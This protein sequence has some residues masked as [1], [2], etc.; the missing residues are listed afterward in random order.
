MNLKKMVVLFGLAMAMLASGRIVFAEETVVAMTDQEAAVSSQQVALEKESDLQWAWGE[1]TNLDNQAG[2]V[3]LKYL[4]YETDQEKELVL[5]VDEKT[6]FENINDFSQLKL[7]DA[8]SIDYIAG[9]DNKNIAKNIS[10]EKADIS[11]VV[12]V[13]ENS[14][15][16]SPASIAEQP[17]ADVSQPAIPLEAPALDLAPST[18]PAVALVDPSIAVTE[19]PA[20]VELAPPTPVIPELVPAVQKQAQ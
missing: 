9:V 12:P 14:E 16:A 4:D 11:S 1:V 3:T 20:P 15:L 17:V 13:E 2:T 6:T 7:G 8:L 10:F 18:T 19:A 5:M